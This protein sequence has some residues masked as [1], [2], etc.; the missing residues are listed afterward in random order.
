[1]PIGHRIKDIKVN[2][3]PL[4]EERIYTLATNDF[5]F[6]G[7]DG[8]DMLK[9]VKIVGESDTCETIFARYLNEVGMEG[10]ETGRLQMEKTIELPEETADG[11]G[12]AKAA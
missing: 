1:M 7:G 4:D 8:Y 6:A 3:A 9:G 10:I 5:L 11:A 2:G 12:L